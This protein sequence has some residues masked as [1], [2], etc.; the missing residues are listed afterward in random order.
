M[1]NCPGS[2][3]TIPATIRLTVD[4]D[5]IPHVTHALASFMDAHSDYTP[6]GIQMAD[7]KAVLAQI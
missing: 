5:E 3:P 2:D 6:A 7:L 1:P 4:D